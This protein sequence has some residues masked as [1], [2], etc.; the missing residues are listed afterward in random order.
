MH[1]N[2]NMLFEKL[3]ENYLAVTPSAV[4][5]HDLFGKTQ[6]QEVINDHIALRTFNL[7]NIGLS[8]L[9]AH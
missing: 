4:T 8:A 7:P 6:G 2:V 3:W 9:A 1:T 5:V